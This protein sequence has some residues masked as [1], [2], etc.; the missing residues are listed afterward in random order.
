MC[1][2]PTIAVF[3]IIMGRIALLAARGVL[4]VMRR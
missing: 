4:M 3:L 1:T 2:V